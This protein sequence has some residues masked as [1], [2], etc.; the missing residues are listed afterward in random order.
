MR[1]HYAG[2]ATAQKIL[3]ASLWWPMLHKDSK[4]YCK[5]CDECQRT[6]RPSRRDEFPLHP[7]VSLQPLEKWAIDFVGPIH[8]P[9]KKTV[10]WDYRTTGK[11]LT[12]KTSFR[13]VYGVEVVMPLEYIVP[14]LRITSLTGMADREALEERLKQLL[15]LEEDRF[16]AGFHQQV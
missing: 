4:A 6:G 5:A 8:P 14:S 13:L 9:G 12:G 16:L 11:K 10:L 7:Q 2:K 1:G 15:E 3:R